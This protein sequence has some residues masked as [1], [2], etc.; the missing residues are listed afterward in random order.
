MNIKISIVALL[1]ISFFN[2]GAVSNSK[3]VENS[4]GMIETL[5]MNQTIFKENGVKL[6]YRTNE[7]IIEESLRIKERLT[8]NVQ[9]NYSEISKNQ[10]QLL[11]DEFSINI[12][13]WNE[14]NYTYVEIILINKNYKYD[15]E[16]LK[17]ILNMVIDDNSKF[18]QYFFYYEGKIEKNQKS[19]LLKELKNNIEKLNILDISNGCTG[20][21]FLS[22]GEKVNFALTSYNT[23]SYIIIGTPIIFATY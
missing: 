10:F 21:G 1:L 20:N 12:K 4:F 19:G 23:G 9:G 17:S 2:L 14:K 7:K 16:K 8:D 18:V 5:V 6:Q 13:L 3:S 11:N 15:L 22:N